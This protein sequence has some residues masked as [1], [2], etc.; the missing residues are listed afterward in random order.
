MF[1]TLFGASAV[2]L[3][4]ACTAALIKS[5]R[6]DYVSEPKHKKMLSLSWFAAFFHGATLWNMC[7]GAGNVN[8]DLLSVSSLAMLM[9]VATLLIAALFKPLDKLGIILFPMASVFILLKMLFPQE[10]HVLKIHAWQMD[11]HILTSML[12]YSFLNIAAMQAVLLAYQDRHLHRHNPN[13]FIASLPPLQTMEILLFQLIAAGFFLLSL[14][15]LSG[16]IF[17]EN[18]F[19]QHLVHKTVISI[20]AWLVF[21][22]LLWGR[23]RYGWRGQTASCWAL[24]G[25]GALM[26]AYF[27]SKA[28]LELILH[29][30]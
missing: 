6:A 12:A 19:S 3:Y 20:L 26:L 16:F 11:L 22:L 5:L 25:F 21:A 24:S 30:V 29:R 23:K 13:R 17:L 10:F 27:G 28:V 4:L 9:I 1:P 14:S 2:F 7:D 15:L 18:I 8:F